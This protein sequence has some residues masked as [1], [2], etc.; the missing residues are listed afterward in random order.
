MN[1]A[2][3]ILAR[4]VIMRSPGARGVN[5]VEK[6]VSDAA[7]RSSFELDQ[8]LDTTLISLEIKSG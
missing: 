5:R 4:K 7:Q 1:E 8:V 2:D 3:I 6:N